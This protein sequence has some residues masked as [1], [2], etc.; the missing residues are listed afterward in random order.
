MKKSASNTGDRVVVDGYDSSG[1]YI[2][3]IKGTVIGFTG[4]ATQ[5]VRL[6]S[7]AGNLIVE[8]SWRQCRRLILKPRRRI[9][10]NRDPSDAQVAWPTREAAD[11][12]A[13]PSRI[14]CTEFVEVRRGK[15]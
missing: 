9:W 12:A 4:A 2:N 5:R 13:N 15:R 10:L 3:G 6:D 11:R 7:C 1:S 8:V 14:S